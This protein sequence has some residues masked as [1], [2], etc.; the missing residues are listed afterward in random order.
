MSASAGEV[1]NVFSEGPSLAQYLPAIT[2]GYLNLT[3]GCLIYVY[4]AVYALII[5]TH[6]FIMCY[7]TDTP[8]EYSFVGKV[9]SGWPLVILYFVAT[10]LS[11]YYV[12][13]PDQIEAN[14]A[15]SLTVFSVNLAYVF[16]LVYIGVTGESG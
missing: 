3:T 1:L 5:G 4:F 10:G 14:Y 6:R 13:S 15:I 12:A 11:G 8:D 16:G 7:R 9:L 2:F